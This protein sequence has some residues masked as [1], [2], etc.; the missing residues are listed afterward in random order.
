MRFH[1]NFSLVI[2]YDMIAK[3]SETVGKKDSWPQFLLMLQTMESSNLPME[4]WRKMSY[5]GEVHMD[6]NKLSI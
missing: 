6:A 1:I 4:G 3:P 5:E 2:I